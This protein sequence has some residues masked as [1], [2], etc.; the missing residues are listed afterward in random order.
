SK[1]ASAKAARFEADVT[2]DISFGWFLEKIYK[3]SHFLQERYEFV[4][5][6][7]LFSFSQYV[8]A[9]RKFFPGSPFTSALFIQT[10]A[11]SARPK[12]RSQPFARNSNMPSWTS[13]WQAPPMK[14]YALEWV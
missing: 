8:F 14:L 10:T 6:L 11:I 13:R 2:E 1:M 9:G 4:P 7:W 5:G 3:G 12:R